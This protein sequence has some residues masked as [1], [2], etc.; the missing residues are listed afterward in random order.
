VGSATFGGTLGKRMIPGLGT[1][2]RPPILDES[3][4][5][6]VIYMSEEDTVRTCHRLAARGFLFGGSTGT[7]INGAARWLAEHPSAD[8]RLA[9][10][11]APDLGDRY[12][13][14]VYHR[15][16]VED[17]YGP[18]VL[19]D[20]DLFAASSSMS[21]VSSMQSSREGSTP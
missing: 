4:V 11:I 19:A 16:W 20:H 7:V 9:V 1:T 12:L 21:S 15:A 2:V 10:A 14:S 6:D 17:I 13:D 5:D 8:S 18:D 3:L